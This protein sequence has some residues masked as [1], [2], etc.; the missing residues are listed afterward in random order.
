M[1]LPTTN[2]FIRFDKEGIIQ[3]LKKE[4]IRSN[5]KIRILLAER[6]DRIEEKIQQII[7]E[8]PTITIRYIYQKTAKTKL[9]TIISD[10]KSSLVIE[11]K[12]DSKE[13]NIEAIGKV[14][15]SAKTIPSG[16]GLILMNLRVQLIA[17]LTD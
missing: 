15:E 12:D 11:L 4:A 13:A 17:I 1:I 3:Y 5:S 7:K 16:S 9:I 6:D 2:T 8:Y 14:A 10:S